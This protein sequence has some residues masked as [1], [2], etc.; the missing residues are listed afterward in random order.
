MS[1]IHRL[2][3]LIVAA[4][5]AWAGPAGA[6][7]FQFSDVSGLAAEAEFTLVNPTTLQVRLRNTSSGVPGGFSNSDQL[8]T[9]V[10]WDFGAPGAGVGDV[11]IVS[12]SVLTGASSASLN[13]DVQSVG[14]NADVSGEW[15][16]SNNDMT[17]LLQN[18]LTATSAQSTAFG[19]TNLDG[20]VNIDG[21]QGGLVASPVPVALGGLGA[22]QDEVV[23]T[24]VLSGPLADLSFLGANGVRVEFGSDAA[25][26][27]GVLVPEPGGLVALGLAALVW[28]SARRRR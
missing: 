2:V 23:A 13:F 5:T 19:G 26:L 18:F 11:A 10:S 17:G 27:N 4:G 7:T 24:L 12:G 1:G 21:P 6:L 22:V 20:P 14:S 25:F 28:R 15:G 8:L 9:G 16:Y 3:L